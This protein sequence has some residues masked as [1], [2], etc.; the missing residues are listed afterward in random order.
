MSV[1]GTCAVVDMRSFDIT[2][3]ERGVLH[4]GI[5]TCRDAVLGRELKDQPA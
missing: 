1:S 5:W 2:L 4:L 3:R